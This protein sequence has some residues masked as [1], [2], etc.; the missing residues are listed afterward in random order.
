M[1][2][3]VMM[4][5]VSLLGGGFLAMLGIVMRAI[6]SDMARIENKMD[7]G[8]ARVDDKFA[9]VHGRID[10]L[11][12]ALAQAGSLTGPQPDDLSPASEVVTRG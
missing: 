11:I 6:R 7:A 5:L 3:I 9:D 12:M 10:R 1:E 4:A 2:S 8:F